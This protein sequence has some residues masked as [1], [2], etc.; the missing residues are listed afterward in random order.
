MSDAPKTTRRGLLAMWPRTR[1]PSR[2][3]PPELPEQEVRAALAA[4]APGAPS[5]AEKGR[6]AH[7]D[8]LLGRGS[9]APDDARGPRSQ[10]GRALPV[11]PVVRPPGAVHER[12]FVERCDGCGAC[13][14]ACPHG[15]IVPLDARHGAVAGTP[16]IVGRD[17]PCRMCPDMPCLDACDRGALSEHASSRIGVAEIRQYDCLS[18][19]GTTCST[20]VERCPVEAIETRDGRPRVAQ[21]VCTGCGECQHRCPAPRNAILIVARPER[22]T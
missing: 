1:A 9:A 4:L 20:C 10:R 21:E 6:P 7:L 16:T 13:V 12:L 15:V 3:G 22:V 5:I 14:E 17:A 18:W 19:S 11:L 2:P 8:R